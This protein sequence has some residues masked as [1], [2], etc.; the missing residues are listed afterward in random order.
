MAISAVSNRPAE[1]VQAAPT[2]EKPKVRSTDTDGDSD[3]SKA[4]ET[5]NKPAATATPPASK[6]TETLGNK[7]DTYA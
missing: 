1:P 2:P 5:E 4:R 3:A 7:V 6:P